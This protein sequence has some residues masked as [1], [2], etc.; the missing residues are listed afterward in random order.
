VNF[1]RW[2]PEGR[3][4]LTGSASGEF[5]LW[6]GT[7]FNF[8]TIMQAHDSNIRAMSYSHNDDWLVS[9]DQDGVIKYWQTNFNNVK[10]IQGHND[11][12]RD[13]AFSP[14]DTK[15]VT[16][17]DDSTLK[18]FDFAGGV[19]ESVLTGHGWECK[20]ADWHPTK[21]LL[22]SGSKDHLVKLWDPRTGRCL[23][24][25]HGH[26]NTITATVFEKT[27]GNCLGTSAREQSARI[28]D[29]RMMRDICILK[30]HEKDNI[31]SL[32]FHPIHPSLVSTAGDGPIYHYL[33]DEPNNPPGVASTIAPYDSPDPTTTPAQT[34]YPAHKP[35]RHLVTGLAPSW[36]H[37]RIRLKRPQHGLLDACPTRRHGDQR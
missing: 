13:I 24:T 26:K 3:R 25:L 19:E 4:L 37:P 15:F 32:V 2:T 20:S 10:I 33:L 28:F 7:G 5:T 22:V 16:A 1:V 21:G 11:A 14:N 9:A 30:G 31:T 12:I 18:I 27:R 6:N 29:L 23:T 35:I 36:S 17:S 34:I 8:E